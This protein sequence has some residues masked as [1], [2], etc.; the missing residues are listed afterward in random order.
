VSEAAGLLATRRA[1]VLLHPSSLPSPYGRGDLGHAAY[2]FVEFLAAAGCSVWQVLPLGPTHPDRSPYNAR[3]VHAGDPELI[4]LDWLRDRELLTDN[5]LAAQCADHARRGEWLRAAARRFAQRL[6]SDATLAADYHAFCTANADWLPSYT[7][8]IA[9]AEQ[10]GSAPWQRWPQP[11][12]DREPAAIEAALG[13]AG[14]RLAALC[15]EQY[16]FDRQWAELRAY[17]AGHGVYLFGDIPIFVAPDSADVWWRRELF[18]LDAAGLPLVETG[19]P[20]DYFSTEGQRWGNPHYDWA[21]MAEDGFAWWHRRVARQRERFD[22][23]RI[24]H[25]R[26]FE[27]CWEIPREAASAAEGHW[28]SAPGDALLPVLVHAAG[29][30]VLVAENLGIITP[31]VE[32]LRRAHGLPGMRVLQFGFDGDPHNPHLP[33]NHETCEVVYTGTHDNDTTLG[34]FSSLDEPSRA[35]VLEYL[36]QPG[37]PMPWPLIRA[38]MASVARLAI[39]PMQDLLELGSEGR[40]NQPGLAGGNWGW[41]LEPGGAGEGLARRLRVLT[42]TYGRS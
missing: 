32:Q 18:H 17:A 22:L 14:E 35:R 16:V 20:P 7:Q 30:G 19:V 34:W 29:P 28:A 26:G 4:S 15:F 41:Q 5:E 8:Y 6:A 37:E 2:R 42:K 33:H 39:I 25:F 31:A 12:R 1:G 36:R 10:Q 9:L 11:L 23:L 40:M 24:D 3:S 13:A 21:R 27:A 38:A